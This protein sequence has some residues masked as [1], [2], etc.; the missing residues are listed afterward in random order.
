MK[1]FALPVLPDP[2]PIQKVPKIF[3]PKHMEI[4]AAATAPISTVRYR[5]RT[6]WNSPRDRKKMKIPSTASY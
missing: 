2:G 6:V 3:L 5:S 1:T 4:R